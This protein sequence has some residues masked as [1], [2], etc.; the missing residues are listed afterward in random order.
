M[1]LTQLFNIYQMAKQKI[2][3]SPPAE[4]DLIYRPWIHNGYIA[5]YIGFLN[6][7]LLAGQSQIDASLRAAVQANLNFLLTSRSTGFDKDNP[8][9]NPN[10]SCSS[11]HYRRFNIAR[12]FIYLT[13]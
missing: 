9:T 4:L 3:L 6:L 7:Q 11:I 2:D 1:T 5:G 8:C 13:P 10:Y 12:N